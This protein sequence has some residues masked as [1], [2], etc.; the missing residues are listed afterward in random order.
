MA[1]KSDVIYQLECRRRGGQVVSSWFISKASA[2]ASARKLT[3][4]QKGLIR[5]CVLEDNLVTGRK[6]VEKCY[7]K[8][9]PLAGK[10]RR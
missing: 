7:R 9:R 8:G 3:K 10:V 5:C 2:R 1:R 6:K 4:H